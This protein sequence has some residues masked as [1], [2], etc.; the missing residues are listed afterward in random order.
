MAFR[1]F[2]EG[3]PLPPVGKIQINQNILAIGIG[4]IFLLIA[5]L[6]FFL[7]DLR[8]KFVKLFGG[9]APDSQ[10][11]ILTELLQRCDANEKEIAELKSRANVLEAVS[12]ISFQ[13]I[14]FMRFNPFA[15]TGGDQSF[16]LAILDFENNGFV[17]S[18]LHNREG[19]R[20]YAKVI[21]HGN[22]KQSLS[23]EEEEVL[24]RAI[25]KNF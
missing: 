7:F 14:G 5:V 12:K 10:A 24:K 1:S 2:N 22:P 4:I 15:D 21:D 9:K 25:G 16:A 23:G 3:G 6:G 13:K 8:G 11:S 19:T 18:S 17:I 20:I